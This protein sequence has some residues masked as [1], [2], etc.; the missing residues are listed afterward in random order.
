[1]FDILY[2]S[3]SKIGHGGKHRMVYELQK[4]YK[5]ATQEIISIF[6]KLCKTCQLK[7]NNPR[8]GLVVKPMVHSNMNDRCQ[9]DLID[10]QSNP[11]GV[12]KFILVYQDHLTK[13]CIL[14][15]LQ[16]KTAVEVAKHVLD[17]F[18]IFGAPSIIQS[19]NGREFA[20]SVIEELSFMWKGLKI[21]HGKPRH[22]QSQ[23][24]VERANQDIQNMLI[25]WMEEEKS[26]HW[27]EGL[28]FV[29]FMKNQTL[30]SGIQRAPYRA[31]FGNDAKFGLASKSIPE[32]LYCK[33]S[34]EED[35]LTVLQS[36]NT[37]NTETGNEQDSSIIG[38]ENMCENSENTETENEQDP[39]LI[40]NQNECEN[41]RTENDQN[42]CLIENQ[43]ICDN[44]K[45]ENE[46]EILKNILPEI[47]HPQKLQ[48]VQLQSEQLYFEETQFQNN[49]LQTLQPM[50]VTT[51]NIC[52]NCV[53]NIPCEICSKEFS[54]SDNRKSAKR[55]L[56]NQASKMIK[57]S[58]SKFPNCKVGDTVRVGI[59]D[60]DRGRGDFRNILMAIIEISDNGLYKLANYHGT[61][62]E[63]FSRN[64]FTPTNA[65]H[66]DVSKI[67]T[68]KKSL[69]QLAIMAS[70][71]GGQGFQR[72]NC[73]QGCKTNKCKCKSNG[74]KCNSK[75]HSSL[76][77]I[78]K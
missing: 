77:C 33:L 56:D 52:K 50:N 51:E 78:N 11:D 28:K 69:R 61:I 64:Q 7:Q 24:S 35:L 48:P 23:G 31:M 37:M 18:C 21:V 14:R 38:N 6:L 19:D 72:C 49:E 34:S 36:V 15:P 60:V 62:E 57:R 76:S 47:F 30:H 46:Q 26:A 63:K 68:E 8:K 45:T 25:S 71:F 4:K 58:N 22:S 67:S 12:F 65:N 17:I 53:N 2:K 42:P 55:A 9:I 32:S 1:M 75:C 39:C 3:H 43:N 54:I 44:N 40:Q 16:C 73:K 5:N 10:M 70:K 74:L 13:F 59:P 66:I 27:S 29:Q 20:N 41:T